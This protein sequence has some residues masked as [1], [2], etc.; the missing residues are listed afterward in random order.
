MNPQVRTFLHVSTDEVFGSLPIGS[1]ERFSETSP[2]A[3]NSV[4]ASTKAAGDHLC[5]A[6]FNTW[7]LPI[8]V[9]HSANNFGPYQLPEK[10]VPFAIQ[11]LL[12]GKTIPLYG[13]GLQVR[14]WL[15]VADHVRALELCLLHGKPGS[16]YVVGAEEEKT[17]REIAERILSILEKDASHIEYITDR[18]GHDRRYASDSALIRKELGWKPEHSFDDA[19]E[20]TVTWYMTN[21]DWMQEVNSRLGNLNAHI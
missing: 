6:Y 7:K 1:S 2:Y 21:Q 14:D 8:V 16:V 11:R 17:N 4:Y 10:L 3:P 12:E 19:F 20:I 13:D 18:P 9:T 5:R 15:H